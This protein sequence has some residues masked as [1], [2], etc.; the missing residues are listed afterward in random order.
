[1]LNKELQPGRS[2]RLK[3][4]LAAQ[5]IPAIST[6]ISP[7]TYVGAFW[8]A[9]ETGERV[10]RIPVVEGTEQVWHAAVAAYG[11]GWD[12][13]NGDGVALAM[14]ESTDPQIYTDSP[15]NPENYKVVAGSTT[16]SNTASGTPSKPITFRVGLQKPFLEYNKET[17]PARYALVLLYFAGKT[18]YF[19]IR[20]GEGDDYLMRP[21]SDPGTPASRPS[22]KKFSPYNLTA[23]DSDWSANPIDPQINPH[24][25]SFTKYPTQAGALFQWSVAESSVAT[26]ARRAYNPTG[27]GAMSVA[28]NTSGY[29]MAPDSIVRP[30]F[31]ISPNHDYHNETCPKG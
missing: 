21:V 1:M 29:W 5:S 7:W 10:I 25:G 14:G 13:Q 24:G 17:K 11:P 9:N 16:L 3:V 20:Q 2:Y 15:G 19:F 12:P 30:P 18:Q 6:P 28:T 26:D 8:R 27:S 22:A 4:K 31:T 23:S